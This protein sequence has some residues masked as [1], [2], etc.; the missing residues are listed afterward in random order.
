MPGKGILLGQHN[1]KEK[2]KR[3]E[4]C[5]WGTH[6]FL[7]GQASKSRDRRMDHKLRGL[8]LARRRNQWLEEEGLIPTHI[9]YVIKAIPI[10]YASEL[11]SESKWLHSHYIERRLS[12]KL[13]S[14]VARK[15][16]QF[17]A[18]SNLAFWT[19]L[20]KDSKWLAERRDPIHCY[21]HWNEKHS[22]TLKA[23]RMT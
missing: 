3:P 19:G 12:N 13:P 5:K 23:E 18:S 10:W 17:P 22:S 6:T 15:H 1:S 8:Q 20:K 16:E 7:K 14:F 2:E 4:A 9:L 11:F 21:F